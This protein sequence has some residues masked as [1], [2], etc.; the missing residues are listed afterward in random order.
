MPVASFICFDEPTPLQLLIEKQMFIGGGSLHTHVRLH[1]RTA[2]YKCVSAVLNLCGY[3]HIMHIISFF[4][5]G[6]EQSKKRL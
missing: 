5:S 6:N 3:L 1:K 4:T 2:A